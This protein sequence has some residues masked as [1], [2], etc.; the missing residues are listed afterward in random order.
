MQQEKTRCER[1]TQE[2]NDDVQVKR[3]QN[4]FPN[5]HVTMNNA[6]ALTKTTFLVKSVRT[7][8]ALQGRVVCPVLSN[9]RC[10]ICNATRKTHV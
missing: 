8:R 9:Y 2:S 1:V 6:D 10:T 7:S 5:F 3:D 4:S